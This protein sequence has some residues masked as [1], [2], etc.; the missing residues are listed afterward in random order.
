MRLEGSA[1]G[2]RKTGWLR[3]F[4]V[5]SRGIGLKLDQSTVA[6]SQGEEGSVRGILRPNEARTF[7]DRYLR[8]VLP[9]ETELAARKGL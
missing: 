1:P 4:S 9:T 6:Q 7:K 3:R 8:G 5:G 2:A